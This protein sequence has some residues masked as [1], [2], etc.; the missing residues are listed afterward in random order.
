MRAAEG[1][2]RRGEALWE[3]G[4]KGHPKQAC[5][6]GMEGEEERSDEWSKRR[7]VRGVGV[8]KL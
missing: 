8:M 5:R 2:G 1:E 6:Y 4:G 3:G 7:S